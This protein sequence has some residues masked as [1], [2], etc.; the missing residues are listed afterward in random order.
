MALYIGDELI[1]GD[2]EGQKINNPFSL[3][4]FRFSD[5]ILNNTSWLRADTF[6]W[7]S[8]VVYV[9][10]YEHLVADIAGITAETEN[11]VGMVTPYMMHHYAEA[12]CKI[13]K[14]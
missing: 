11:I 7:A 8:G 10:A 2:V 3:F 14:K 5:Q 12:L 1:A 4:D 9:S 6:S 13:G